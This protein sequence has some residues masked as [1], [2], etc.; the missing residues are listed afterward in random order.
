MLQLQAIGATMSKPSPPPLKPTITESFFK[1]DVYMCTTVGAMASLQQAQ[2]SSETD[3]VDDG[4]LF[5]PVPKTN[6]FCFAI[7]S[8]PSDDPVPKTN[9]TCFAISSCPSDDGLNTEK[10]IDGPWL[11]SNDLSLVRLSKPKLF[12]L[13]PVEYE[14]VSDAKLL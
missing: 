4:D 14:G 10:S 9:P 8:C 2:T 13:A 6:P 12:E 5:H 7:S 3:K 11:S 1:S